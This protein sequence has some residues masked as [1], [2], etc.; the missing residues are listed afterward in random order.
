M[1]LEISQNSQEN[2]CTRV[3]FLVKLQASAC[4]FIKKETLAQ[5]FF[6]EFFEISENPLFYR[7][8]LGDCFERPVTLKYVSPTENP[9]QYF[10]WIINSS[11][12]YLFKANN[13]NTRTMCEI[14]SKSTVMALDA[15]VG[16]EFSSTFQIER[17]SLNFHIIV[18]CTV[19][20]TSK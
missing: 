3:S 10:K 17:K 20:I 18:I 2:T 7:T 4:N 9:N 19:E 14:C 8:T 16:W 5:L 15:N 1:L 11:S 6:C 13:G 12:I